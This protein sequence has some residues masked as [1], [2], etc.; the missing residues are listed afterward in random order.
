MRV[1]IILLL[2]LCPSGW[3]AVSNEYCPVLPDEKAEAEFK[4]IYKGKE[5]FLCCSKCVRNFNKNPEE[6]LHNLNVPTSHD[7]EAHDHAEANKWLPMMIARLHPVIV[8]FPIAGIFFAFFL[9]MV[10]QVR[11]SAD[12]R[13]AII[14]V[15]VVASVASVAA[16]ISGWLNAA[17]RGMGS[18]DAE[19]LTSHR[20][21][22]IISIVTLWGTTW[23]YLKNS[24][25]LKGILLVCLII[26]LCLVS[27]TG[28]LGGMLVFGLEYF[29]FGSSGFRVA[30][31]GWIEI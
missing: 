4:T 10:Q 7:A 30:E 3:A 29:N 28:H 12:G 19:V 6:Y 25:R 31:Y 24:E 23:L 20:W 18:G 26:T 11:K 14:T 16:G 22:G 13:V 15:L 9:Q 8:H 27:A 2:T 1:F 5:I 21:L 17:S